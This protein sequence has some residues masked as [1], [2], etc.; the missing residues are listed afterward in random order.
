MDFFNRLGDIITET[1]KQVGKRAKDF[2]QLSQLQAQ[3]DQETKKLTETYAKIGKR[4][5]ET[6]ELTVP[7]EY[8]DLFEIIRKKE[9]TIAKLKA[10]VAQCKGGQRCSFCGAEVPMHSLYCNHCGEKMKEVVTE[11]ELEKQKEE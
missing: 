5:Y 10:Q 7:Q 4:Y 2:A 6:M 11:V 3:L 8:E 1:G 9:Q